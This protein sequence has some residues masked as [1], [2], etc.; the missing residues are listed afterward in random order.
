MSDS[1]ENSTAAMATSDVEVD[2]NDIH[3]TEVDLLEITYIH[4]HI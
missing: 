1:V 2:E 3:D 4:L